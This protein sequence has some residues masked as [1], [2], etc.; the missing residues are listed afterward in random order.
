M[1][2]DEIKEALNRYLE[3]EKTEDGSRI[4]THCLYP[5]F[6][7]VSVYIIG[8]GNGYIVHDG[9]TASGVAWSHGRDKEIIRKSI[10]KAARRFGVNAEAGQI[11]MKID[12]A[13]WLESAILAVSNASA[14]AAHN[15]VDQIIKITEKNLHEIIREQIERVI[16]KKNVAT[17]YEISGQSGKRYRFDFGITLP[18]HRIIPV[19]GVVAHA[20]SVTHKFVAFSDTQEKFGHTGLAAHQGDLSN[21]DQSLLSQVSTL[22]PA[23]RLGENLERISHAIH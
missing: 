1:A 7:S 20:N 21:A 10:A 9:S 18:D 2:C 22:V 6:E 19:D 8:Y 4:H 5:S 23:R 12:S 16:P 17:E 14:M 3:C 13:E 15:A 11:S